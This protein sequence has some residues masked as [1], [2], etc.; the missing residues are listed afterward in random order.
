[1]N[2]ALNPLPLTGDMGYRQ[3]MPFEG[4][5]A[6]AADIFDVPVHIPVWLV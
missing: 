6:C 2:F 5:F 4:L 3:D 1:M